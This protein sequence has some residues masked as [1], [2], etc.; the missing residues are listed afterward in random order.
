MVFGMNQLTFIFMFFNNFTEITKVHD[1]EFI[2]IMCVILTTFTDVGNRGS[3]HGSV[4]V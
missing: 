1:V 2:V 4:I 3:V